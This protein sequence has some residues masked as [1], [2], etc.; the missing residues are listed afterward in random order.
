MHRWMVTICMAGGIAAAQN[1]AGIPKINLGATLDAMPL[2]SAW[3]ELALARSRFIEHD[4]AAAIAPLATAAAALETYERQEPGPNGQAAGQI[5]EEIDAYT[6][7]V[8]NDPG[9]ALSR[10]Q[11]WAARIQA[12]CKDCQ[13]APAD[14][15]PRPSKPGP[16]T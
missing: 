13:Y 14:L 1:G 10:I 2:S 11:D 15:V 8:A 16:P 6:L 9:D 7:V 5:C 4:D 3:E 12:L